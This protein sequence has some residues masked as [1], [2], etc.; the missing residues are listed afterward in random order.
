MVYPAE[1]PEQPSARASAGL[2][3]AHW[4]QGI[5]PSALVAFLPY[6]FREFD[7]LRVEAGIFS[8]CVVAAPRGRGGASWRHFHPHRPRSNPK[9]TRVLEKCG[10]TFEG[11]HR[12]AVVKV[13]EVAGGVPAAAL[14]C[15]AAA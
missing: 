12:D 14:P 1:A 10:F 13:G 7:L 4:G 5:V 6:A 3:Q 11:R 15:A 2:G 9:S 8:L